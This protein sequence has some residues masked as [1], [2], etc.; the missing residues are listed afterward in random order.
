MSNLVID[1]WTTASGR[2]IRT[3][4]TEI[5]SCEYEV[6]YGEYTSIIR[7]GAD[8]KLESDDELPPFVLMNMKRSVQDFIKRNY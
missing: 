5:T 3:A 2:K 1:G 7:I 4:V 8:G 6:H